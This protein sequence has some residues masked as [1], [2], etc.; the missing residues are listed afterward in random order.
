MLFKYIW[1]IIKKTKGTL[2]QI[3]GTED[4]IHILM[5]LHPTIAL[6]DMIKKIKIDTNKYIKRNQLF[7]HFTNW[8][9]GYA[10]FTFS[11]NDKERLVRYVKN[12][13]KHHQRISFIDEYKQLLKENNIDFSDDYL[14]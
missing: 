8:Q 14:P 4:H 2:F 10:A 13:E 6:A 3:N 1:G 9:D 7:P 12:Q 11:E 5:D